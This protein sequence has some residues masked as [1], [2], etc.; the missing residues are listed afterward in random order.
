M[1][2]KPSVLHV[3]ERLAEKQGKWELGPSCCRTWALSSGGRVALGSAPLGHSGEKLP[4]GDAAHFG[5]ALLGT[6][7]APACL[8]VIVSAFPHAHT[9]EMH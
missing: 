9:V 3:V 8:R 2:H 5:G 4:A 6:D 7:L 1:P